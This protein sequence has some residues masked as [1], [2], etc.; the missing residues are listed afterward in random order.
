MKRLCGCWP[1]RPVMTGARPPTP[2]AA[3]TPPPPSRTSLDDNHHR[4]RRRG[5]AGGP[6]PLAGGRAR[7]R[8]VL[9]HR[10]AR[11]PLRGPGRGGGRPDP[12]AAA[13][14]ATHGGVEHHRGRGPIE[15]GDPTG[16]AAAFD[17]SGDLVLA[18]RTGEPDV[19]ARLRGP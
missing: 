18:L 6:G 12:L 10:P 16:V 5:V 7:P 11:W 13:G 15:L 8:G 19:M 9:G 17:P 2:D 14:G 4:H 3:P 1:W